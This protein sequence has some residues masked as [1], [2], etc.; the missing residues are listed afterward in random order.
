MKYVRAI[1][2]TSTSWIHSN[3][4]ISRQPL[5]PANDDTPLPFRIAT[6]SLPCPTEE[7]RRIPTGSLPGQSRF[8][9]HIDSDLN[10]CDPSLTQEGARRRIAD[11]AEAA[12]QGS[13]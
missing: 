12:S 10:G 11:L 5:V 1:I 7:F 9:A 6:E 4:I 13:D 8:D 2:A 3:V